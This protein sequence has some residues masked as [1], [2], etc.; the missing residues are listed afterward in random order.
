MTNKKKGIVRFISITCEVIGV[1]ST[2][3]MRHDL[4]AMLHAGVGE[5]KVMVDE[6]KGKGL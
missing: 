3:P 6:V 2:Y 5:L 4:C 1:L